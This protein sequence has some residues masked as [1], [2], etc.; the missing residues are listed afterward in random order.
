MDQSIPKDDLY[1]VLEIDENANEDEIK[2][3]YR[4]LSLKHHPDRGGDG[5]TFKKINEAYQHLSDPQLKR[6]YD[7][8]RKGFGGFGEFAGAFQGPNVSSHGFPGGFATPEELFSSIFGGG[9]QMPGMPP[10][11]PG[12]QMPPGM[13]MKFSVFENGVPVEVNF[14][15]NVIH[16]PVPITMKLNITMDIVLSG[17][18]V[19]I[20]IKRWFLEG[21]VKKEETVKIYVDVEKGIDD[22]EVLILEGQGNV[23]NDKA[24]GDVKLLVNIEQ[25]AQYVRNGL[26]L[27]YEKAITLKEA[28]CGF[29]FDLKYL[30]G[31]SYTINNEA[32]TVTI[33]PGYRKYI[34]NMGITRG[35][36]TG[37]LIIVFK[38]VFP[39]PDQITNENIEKLKELLP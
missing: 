35:G 17:G 25:D 21:G 12:F 22:G 33:T 20:E 28:V 36:T 32:R 31:K 19:P 10:M 27:L 3:S 7:L 30:N 26:D 11:P 9:V 16:K 14:D 8:S 1:K 4:S 23:I 13:Q 29:S 37:N 38:V 24:K 5:E 18:K 6:Q 15:P 34:P 39:T 2:K